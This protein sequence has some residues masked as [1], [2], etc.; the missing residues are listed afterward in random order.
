[1]LLRDVFG[2]LLRRARLRQGRTLAEVAQRARVSTQYLS[3]VERG[4]KEASSEVLA[5]ICGALDVE[6]P[7]LLIA[8][9]RELS[10]AG[11][12]IRL[13]D[14]RRGRPP[15]TSGSGEVRLLIAA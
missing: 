3:E 10:P 15:T 13:A 7:A 14:A 2:L 12:V 6:L 4:R 5:A 11:Q 1:M 9:G 8:A